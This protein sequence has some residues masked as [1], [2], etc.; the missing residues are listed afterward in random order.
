MLAP[1]WFWEVLVIGSDR[2]CVILFFILI[3]FFALNAK[4]IIN[5]KNNRNSQICIAVPP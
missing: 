1:I 3:R 4:S 5:I 2:K